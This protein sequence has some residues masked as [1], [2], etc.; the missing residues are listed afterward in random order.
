MKHFFLLFT[1]LLSGILLFAQVPELMPME[2]EMT[3]LWEPE[4][5]VVTPG[6]KYGDAPSDAIV[7]FDGT[8]LDEEWVNGKDSIPGWTVEN[9]AVTVKRGAGIIK[10]KRTFLDCQLHI[11]WSSPAEVKGTSQGRGNSGVFFQDV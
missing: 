5:P 1:F 8:N 11:E 6:E 9:G 10:T 4:V 2:P 7:L 3:E